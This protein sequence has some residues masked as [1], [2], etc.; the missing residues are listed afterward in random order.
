M[1]NNQYVN[2]VVYDNNTL[3]DITDTTATASDVVNGKSFYL[4]SGQR[5]T[6]TANY[7]PII[8]NPDGNMILV[9]NSNGEAVESSL[10]ET[11]VATEADIRTLNN[12]ISTKANKLI[13]I[14][15]STFS[16]LPQT[17]SNE[18]ITTNHV[19]VEWSLSNSGALVGDWTWTTSTGSIT[20]N[21]A[22]SGTTNIK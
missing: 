4:A 11:D 21:G 16:S 20:I 6:G 12:T 2:K 9:S 22:I 5:T 7:M 17:I 14:T 1:A 8:S 19:V 18:N 10:S 3:I 13:E 15:S